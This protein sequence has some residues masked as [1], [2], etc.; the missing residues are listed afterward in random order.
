MLFL[1]GIPGLLPGPSGIHNNSQENSYGEWIFMLCLLTKIA[2]CFK[3]I[4]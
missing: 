3:N 2:I 4:S 1:L